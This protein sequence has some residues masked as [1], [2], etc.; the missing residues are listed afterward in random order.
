MT[1]KQR[2]SDEILNQLS[3]NCLVVIQYLEDLAEILKTEQKENPDLT[4]YFE[5]SI[6]VVHLIRKRILERVPQ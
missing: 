4:Q 2:P 1:N 5:G 3:L 6:C